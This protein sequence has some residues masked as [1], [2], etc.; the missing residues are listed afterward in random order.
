MSSG[1]ENVI[2]GD[3]E[4]VEVSGELEDKTWKE[5]EGPPKVTPVPRPP[6]PFPQRLVK[7]TEDSKYRHIITMLKQLSINV[8]LVKAFEQMTG[9]AKFMKNM[10]TKKI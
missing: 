8:P 6:H 3:D 5:E 10:V 2:R 4:V 1:V 9:Y 7:K